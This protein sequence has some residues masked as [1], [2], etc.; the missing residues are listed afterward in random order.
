[1]ASTRAEADFK[2]DGRRRPLLG[3]R[4]LTPGAGS[5]C[6][7]KAGNS[8][9]VPV[10]SLCT[11]VIQCAVQLLGSPAGSILLHKLGLLTGYDRYWPIGLPLHSQVNTQGLLEATVGSCAGRTISNTSGRLPRPSAC[12]GDQSSR[13]LVK[14]A[15]GTYGRHSLAEAG[16]CTSMDATWT[17][18][19]ASKAHM[20]M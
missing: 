19:E 3:S 14:A 2:K 4:L 1:M 18:R 12:N 16:L 9:R 13:S 17:W 15:G 7:S 8:R 11:W 10:S 6:R 5:L 20:R